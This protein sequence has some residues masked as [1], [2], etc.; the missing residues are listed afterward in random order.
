MVSR[1]GKDAV[2]GQCRPSSTARHC[3]SHPPSRNLGGLNQANLWSECFAVS[4]PFFIWT[5]QR[6][7][8]TSLADLLMRMSEFKSAE[9][10]P[11]NWRINKPRQFAAVARNWYE[12]KD[13]PALQ[14]GLKAIFAE[15]YLIKHCYELHGT[16]LNVRILRAT[17]KTQYR[18]ILLRR[19]D[20]LSRL[21]SKYIA[22][23]NGTWFKDYASEVYAEIA[24]GSRGL[25]PLPVEEIVATYQHVSR[26]TDRIQEVLRQLGVPWREVWYEDIYTGDRETRTQHLNGLFRFLGFSSE[27]IAA[28]QDEI[29]EKIFSSGQNTRDI[30]RFVPNLTDVRSALAAVG[31]STDAGP[32]TA[33]PASNPEREPHTGQAAAIFTPQK[34][35]TEENGLGYSAKE[36]QR[37]N[38]RYETFIRPQIELIR[39]ARVLDLGSY[40]GRFCYA[41]LESGAAQVV[42]IEQRQDFIDRSRF[43]IAGAMGERV[44]FICDDMFEAL[45]KMI[46]DGERFDVI[47]CL[48]VFYEIM[49]HHRL[50]HLMTQLDPKMI[51]MD[52]N[53]VDSDEAVI[54]LKTVN[55]PKGEAV[56]GTPSRGGIELMARDLRHSVRYAHW[57]PDAMP[58]QDG[59]H[60]YLSTNKVGV[61]RYSFYLE[62]A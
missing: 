59:L 50:L 6:T 46:A 30:L 27:T 18:H 55:G 51:I 3:F 40:D 49:D 38:A 10:E 1:P 2:T 47:L 33:A 34:G 14:S 26:A 53:L 52:T 28:H 9:H 48:G 45:P 23:A 20:E 54:R 15:Q 25:R 36:L 42:G 39:G 19:R 60:D 57:R 21:V 43:I 11:F 24:A 12:T 8:G 31:L 32:E 17:A 35:F 16:P 56:V 4:Y 13:V 5:V 41:A 29:E 61:R 37:H 22:E 62:R 44:R 58:T 7:G